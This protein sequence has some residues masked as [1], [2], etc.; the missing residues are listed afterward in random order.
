MTL[1]DWAGKVPPGE[2]PNPF[3]IFLSPLGAAQLAMLLEHPVVAEQIA[4][5]PRAYA[6]L[7]AV[8]DQIAQKLDMV[9][10]AEM[11]S[12]REASDIFTGDKLPLIMPPVKGDEEHLDYREV[13]HGLQERTTGPRP[14]ARGSARVPSFG[15]GMYLPG[16]QAVN[17]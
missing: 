10:K 6:E 3:H 4:C 8:H 13:R 11:K 1:V 14:F 17:D 9:K 16:G 15:T 12:A 2:K 7:T 5:F